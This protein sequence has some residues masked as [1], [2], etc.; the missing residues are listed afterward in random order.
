MNFLKY[1]LLRLAIAVIAF[2][3]AYYFGAGLMI[4]IICGALI[5]FAIS[6]LA[7]PKLHLAAAADFN[8]WFKRR[9]AKSRIEEENQAF[10][11]RLDEEARQQG[12]SY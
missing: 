3:A 1:S 7:F 9:P 8:G 2:Y 11:D 5:G 6:Y 10:E 12:T 4:S